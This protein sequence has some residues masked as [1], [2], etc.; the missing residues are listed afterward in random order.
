MK[1][2]AVFY[3]SGHG[4]G[5]STR[6][7]A[8][9][10]HLGPDTWKVMLRTSAPEWLY[11]QNVQ[12]PFE[13]RRVECDVGVVQKDSLTT[14]IPETFEAWRQ[15]E[16]KEEEWVEAEARFLKDWS[17]D[18][19]V[20]DIP[21]FAFD[22]A[23]EAGV[24]S[25]GMTNFSWDWIYR[26]Y[27][28]T[29][30]EFAEVADRIAES[31]GKATVLYRLPFFGDLSAFPVIEDVPLV[32]PEGTAR[33][34]E[35][36]RRLGLISAESGPHEE[37]LT[38]PGT[39]PEA[40]VHKK[41]VSGRPGPPASEPVVCV[42]FGGFDFKRF[43]WPEVER[44]A[45]GVRFVAMGS[46][47]PLPAESAILVEPGRMPHTD[48]VEAADLVISKPGYGIV[49]ECI[50]TRTPLLYTSR[51]EFAEYPVLVEGMKK[52]IPTK[53]FPPEDIPNGNVIDTAKQFLGTLSWEGVEEMRCEGAEVVAAK[54][55]NLR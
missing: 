7:Q 54:L 44:R 31:Y 52:H 21:P 37:A 15:F 10:N 11:R 12:R 1:R 30:P 34:D 28:G 32:A 2:R 55:A 18:L 29:V 3:A 19:V 43:P 26:N 40:A 45:P 4:F 22:A 47:G 14:L 41:K 49:A 50:S 33:R 20:A 42:S 17:A 24:P 51:G 39:A 35:V 13:F 9:I 5:H 38:A 27:T 36:R 8:V 48:L 23:A 25:A 46:D 53:F 16:T 6:I